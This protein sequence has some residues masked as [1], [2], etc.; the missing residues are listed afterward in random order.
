MERQYGNIF[1]RDNGSPHAVGWQMR[2][3]QHNFDHATYIVGG[4]YRARLWRL[5]MDEVGAPKLDAGGEKQ[6]V[7]SVEREFSAGMMLLVRAED[8]HEFEC[9]EG[10]GILH[11]V[12]A[13]RDAQ[14]EVTQHATGWEEAYH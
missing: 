10:P 13:H 12:Y 6:F 4:R 2:G 1:V 8:I 3:H 5:V 11:C 7:L 9:L 14:G